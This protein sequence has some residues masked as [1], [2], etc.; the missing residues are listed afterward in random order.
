M[1]KS[2]YVLTLMS[3]VIN[4]IFTVSC[5]EDYLTYEELKSD[6]KKRIE[7]IRA[8]KGLVFLKEYPEDGVFGENEFVEL[9]TGIYLHVVDSGNGNRA[10]INSTTVLIRTEVE[11]Y[12]MYIDSTIKASFFSNAYSPFEFRYGQAYNVV[13]AHANNID[14]PYTYFFSVGLESIL[15]YVGEGAEVKLI[16]PGYSEINN[17]A[18]GSVYQTAST[19]QYIPIYYERVKYTFY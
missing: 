17:V 3:C 12:D 19:R 2:F 8:E 6:E 18:G 11:Y 16:I 7:R 9:S 15:S 10:K 4:L 5:N 14:D 13:T 1:K